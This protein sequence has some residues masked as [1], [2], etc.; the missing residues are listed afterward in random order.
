MLDINLIREK[1]LYVKEALKKKLWDTDFDELLSWDKEKRE[2]MQV[3]E[4]NKAEMNKLSA[5]VPQR[6]WA[7]P[8]VAVTHDH[9]VFA[10]IHSLPM[11]MRTGRKMLRYVLLP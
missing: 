7:V 9:T 11:T 2:L 1:P 6:S 10:F 5:S 4:N 8:P 3:V